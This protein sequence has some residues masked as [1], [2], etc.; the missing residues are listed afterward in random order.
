[1]RIVLVL[2]I[3]LLIAIDPIHA[4]LSDSDQAKLIGI[5][6]RDLRVSE[7][8]QQVRDGKIDDERIRA[9]GAVLRNTNE[10]EIHRMRG[11]WNNEV[12]VSPDGHKEAVFDGKRKPVKD[13]VNDGSYNYFHPQNDALRHFS[14]DIA[15]WL[16]LGNSP[17]DPTGRA[18]RIH[19]YI[20]DL[21]E[22]LNRAVE[23]S[24]TQ[25]KLDDVNL[26]ESGCA[27]SIA[28]FLLAIERGKAEEMIQ[29]VAAHPK[30]SDKELAQLMRSFEGG[31]QS[32]FASEE[33]DKGK[34]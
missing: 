9:I 11:G 1:M 19:A 23:A 13:G 3:V 16:L 33:S 8:V 15:P 22:G 30:K 7:M 21:R 32:L 27:E 20:G 28:I 6:D 18:E 10:V 14:F 31:L 5:L 34:R 24:T 17:N 12:F 26:K 29:V 25:G 2:S 4:Q